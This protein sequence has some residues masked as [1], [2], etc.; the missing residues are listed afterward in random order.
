MKLD[1]EW[2]WQETL[3][4]SEPKKEILIREK[5]KNGHGL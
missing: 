5:E 4:K 3:E 1:S 2:D